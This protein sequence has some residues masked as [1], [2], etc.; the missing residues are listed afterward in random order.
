MDFLKRY[1]AVEKLVPVDDATSENY[2]SLIV[3]YSR[4]SAIEAQEP[5]L[6][7]KYTPDDDQSIVYCVRPLARVY[8]P[9]VGEG[10]TKSYLAALKG[11][12]RL[13]GKDYE[14]VLKEIMS[15]IC[16]TIETIDP[17]EAPSTLM[18][19]TTDVVSLPQPQM[20]SEPLQTNNGAA[21]PV[22]SSNV[23]R[24]IYFDRR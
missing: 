11:L 22:L 5:L 23:K 1:G 15:Q 24:I 13:S 9:K 20:L 2:Q 19:D 3:E 12:A 17:V 10:F 4:S 8:T 14:K 21:A 16:A 7:Y 18:I 6:P